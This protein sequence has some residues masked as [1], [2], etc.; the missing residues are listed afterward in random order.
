[1]TGLRTPRISSTSSRRSST[2]AH[3]LMVPHDQRR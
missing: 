3:E 2:V 1:M